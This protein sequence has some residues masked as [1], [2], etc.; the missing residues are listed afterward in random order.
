MKRIDK[1]TKIKVVEGQPKELKKKGAQK[2]APAAKGKKKAQ[3]RGKSKNGK[4]DMSE[5]EMDSDDSL[6]EFIADD[7][8]SL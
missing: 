8:E 7:D 4:K 1:L 5:D 3:T 2:R 6:N